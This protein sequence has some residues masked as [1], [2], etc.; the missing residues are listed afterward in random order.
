MYFRDLGLLS[1]CGAVSLT[2]SVIILICMN[3]RSA[4]GKA[5][6]VFSRNQEECTSAIL[7]GQVAVVPS[8]SPTNY[9]A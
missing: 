7:D 5:L 4:N 9:G 3:N 6:L 1:R 2:A 8:V